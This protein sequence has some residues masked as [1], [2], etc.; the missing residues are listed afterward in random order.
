MNRVTITTIPNETFVS[1]LSYLRGTSALARGMAS[2]STAITCFT[3]ISATIW[4]K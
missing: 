4:T 3:F 1:F 2:T